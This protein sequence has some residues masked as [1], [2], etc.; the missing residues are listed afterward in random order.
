MGELD[1]AFFGFRGFEAKLGRFVLELGHA[2]KFAYR[3]ETSKDPSQFRMTDDVRL[4]ELVR[5]FR[6]KPTGHVLGHAVENV[7]PQGGRMRRSC[8]RM[9]VDDAEIAFV[10]F[11]HG[12]P[13]AHRPQVV[14]QGELSGGLGA[15]E[16]NLLFFLFGFSHKVFTN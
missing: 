10:V 12:R 5:F 15:S 8:D 6:V 2:L 9:Q 13:V 7:L 14:S 16:D 11:Q 4:G 3:R 1:L